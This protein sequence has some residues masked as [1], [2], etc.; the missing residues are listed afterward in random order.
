ML[1]MP[2]PVNLNDS[3][4]AFL[5]PLENDRIRL[6]PDRYSGLLHGLVYGRYR[7]RLF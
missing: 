4:Y 6:A 3:F 7:E 5:A 1:S 2:S